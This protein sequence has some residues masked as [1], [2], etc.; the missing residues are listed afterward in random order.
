MV[1]PISETRSRS[2]SWFS[3][4]LAVGWRLPKVRSGI[5]TDFF[6][7]L[8]SPLTHCKFLLKHE[9]WTATWMTINKLKLT[10][11]LARNLLTGLVVS[12]K[13]TIICPVA[14]GTVFFSFARLL[15]VEMF[16][17]EY[18][19]YI[20]YTHYKTRSEISIYNYDQWF[21]HKC[22]LFF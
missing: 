12:I 10:S 6:T 14:K 22:H 9:T 16:L 7:K 4:H 15:Q 2:T 8:T 19:L 17:C 11:N 5:A 20:I 13:K 18:V 21:M 1:S 3:L